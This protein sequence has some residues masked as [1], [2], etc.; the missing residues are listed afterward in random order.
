M[1]RHLA[2]QAEAAEPAVGK[3]KVDLVT[4]PPFGPNAHAVAD[5]QHA[6]HQVRIDRGPT[7]HA[8][9]GLQLCADTLQ[10]DEPIDATKQMIV[11]HMIVQGEV[12]EQLRCR[13][14]PAHHRLSLPHRNN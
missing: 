9:E 2:I 3:I 4:K 6:Q 14:L 7:N 8:V 11:R 1:I 10:I 13:D 5:D 12:V